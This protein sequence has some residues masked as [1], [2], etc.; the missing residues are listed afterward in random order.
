MVPAGRLRHLV[1]RLKKGVLPAPFG[2]I[3]AW[4]DPRFTLRLTSLTAMNPLKPLVRFF[5]S[6]IASFATVFRSLNLSTG[7][8]RKEHFFMGIPGITDYWDCLLQQI[9]YSVIP[10]LT[11]IT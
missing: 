1:S 2:P 9:A 5:V 11:S 3:N 7:E 6:S 8:G 4:I 10:P